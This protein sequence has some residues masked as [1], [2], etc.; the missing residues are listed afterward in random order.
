[1]KNDVMKYVRLTAL[2]VSAIV[3]LLMECCNAPLPLE[4][5]A[6]ACLFALSAWCAWKNNDFTWAAK[7][8]SKVMHALKDGKVT[9]DEV[10]AILSE[11][12]EKKTVYT[13]GETWYN[14]Q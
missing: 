1:M 2:A 10:K 9:E 4:M 8:G 3:T 5:I 12:A 11:G 6:L 7:V 13:K 14:D